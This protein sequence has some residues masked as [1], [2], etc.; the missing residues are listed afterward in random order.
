MPG[1]RWVKIPEP[2]ALMQ[3]CCLA[4]HHCRCSLPGRGTGRNINVYSRLCWLTGDSTQTC[5]QLIFVIR[6]VLTMSATIP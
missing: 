1:E 4:P 2:P 5:K 3:G 6:N